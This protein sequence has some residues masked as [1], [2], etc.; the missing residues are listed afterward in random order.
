MK[1]VWISIAVLIVSFTMSD[2][3]ADSR[4]DP[5]EIVARLNDNYFFDSRIWYQ[6]LKAELEG[7]VVILTGESFYSRSVQTAIKT[8]KKAG[9]K[10]VKDRVTMLPDTAAGEGN[11]GVVRVTRVMGTYSPVDVAE[12]K[13]QATELI[14]GD[15]VRFIRS[16][17]KH[18]Q[19]QSPEGYLCYIPKQTVRRMDLNEWDRYHQGPFAIFTQSHKLG[20]DITIN[21]GS[22]LPYLGDQSVLLADGSSL[23]LPDIRIKIIIP[24]ANPV[25]E[26]IVNDAKGYLG[27]PYVWA[28]R[29]DAGVDCS[30]LL[31][32]SYGMNGLFLPRD[33][34]EISNVGRLIAFPGWMSAL[35][36]GDMLFFGGSRRLVTHTGIYM[37]EGYF[38]H[39]HGGGTVIQSLDPEDPEYNKAQHESFLFARRLFE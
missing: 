1:R 11:Y 31:I 28:G 23:E 22:R 6:D 3:S 4:E 7:N 14:Y 37:G 36:P 18:F 10:R 32:Q 33:S 34:D 35:L 21:M 17:E 39:S 16:T 26:E 27:L 20:D 15:P 9:Y 12:F 38:I 24:V 19:V 8:L 5:A 13:D 29:S 25:R 30:G 2:L